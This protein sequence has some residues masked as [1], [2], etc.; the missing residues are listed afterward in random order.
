VLDKEAGT[1]VSASFFSSTPGLQI[2]YEHTINHR[3]FINN[4]LSK[5]VHCEKYNP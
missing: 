5:N 1:Q 2:V 3:N 4:F